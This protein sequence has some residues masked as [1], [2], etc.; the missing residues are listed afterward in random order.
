MIDLKELKKEFENCK[1]GMT[2]TLNIKDICV[3]SG[4]TS[5]VGEILRK[6][7][8]QKRLLL[9]ADKTTLSV[10]EGILDSLKGFSVTKKIY[11]FIREATVSEVQVIKEL[12]KDCDGIIGVGTGTIHDI[13]RKSAAELDKP[14][15]LFATAPSMDGFASYNAPLV[16]G[17]FKI[18]YSAKSPE[19]IIA[20]TK[21]LAKAPPELK[22][23][24]FG[25]M[26][27]KYV[28]L[29]DW[30]VSSEITGEYYCEKVAN[31]TR[32]ATDRIFALADRITKDDEESATE[33]FEA[34][35]LT[36]IG[37]SFT[38][39]SRP[40]SGTEH[41]L[42]HF[43]E[44]K[45]L[46]EG[47]ISD[48]HG[49]KVGVATLLIMKEYQRLYNKKSIKAHKEIIDWDDVLNNYGEL[50][51]EVIKLNTPDTITDDISP[52][53]IEQKWDR[54]RE[55][56]SSVPTEKEIFKGMKTAGCATSYEEIGISEK[57]MKQGL[58]YHPYMRRRLS[59]YRL[60]NMID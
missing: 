30:Q 27:G 12:L 57:L 42:S 55:I 13:C 39:T 26:I 34:L 19:V 35:L 6:N 1:C 51:D 47:E 3:G 45:K 52:E 8:F 44:C 46:L 25:D 5:E 56:I 36:G 15:C 32:K 7:N 9:V 49:K 58:K 50:K 10:S 31:L 17:N 11:P 60:S 37:M 18:T 4:I 2:H 54:I 22:S 38:K 28:G 29:I 53:I 43:W 33:V 16:D 20:D 59:L 24:G 21:I 40:A 48:F 41:I 23:A 14:L